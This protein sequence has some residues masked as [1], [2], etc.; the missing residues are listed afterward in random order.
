[1]KMKAEDLKLI[2]STGN[3]FEDI[4]F[5][6]AEQRLAK[7]QLVSRIQDIIDERGWN[8]KEAGELLGINQP[9]V[10]ALLHGRFEGYSMER[11]LTLL[12]RL[13]QDVIITVKENTSRRNDH[14][15]FCVAFV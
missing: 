5:K 4:G 8:Q 6:D 3:V 7:A 15:H 2:P 11:L 14:G 10:S 9:K 1:M 12:T 13:D